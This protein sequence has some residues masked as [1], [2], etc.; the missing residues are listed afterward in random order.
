[1][2]NDNINNKKTKRQKRYLPLTKTKLTQMCLILKTIRH[3]KEEKQVPNK[4]HD[5]TKAMA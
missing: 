4:R 1:M 2:D 5:K 3:G